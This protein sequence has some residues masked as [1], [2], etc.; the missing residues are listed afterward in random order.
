MAY[1]VTKAG[2][3][4]SGSQ[5]MDFVAE[6]VCLFETLFNNDTLY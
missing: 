1:V 3:N 2:S 4:L 6:Q 5:V